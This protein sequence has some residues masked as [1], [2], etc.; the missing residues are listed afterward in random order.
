MKLSIVTTLY[1]SSEYIYEFHRR[2]SIACEAYFND[3]ELIFVNDGSTDDSLK[4]ILTLQATDD[5]IKIIDLSRNY[6]HHK[7]IMTGL[8]YATGDYVFLTDCDLEEPPESF[9]AFWFE[10]N[11]DHGV[12]VIYATQ[13][14]R[15]GSWWE[16]ISG[17][18]VWRI[19]NKFSTIPI[20]LNLITSRLMN[21]KFISALREFK[22]H[23][24]FLASII[25]SA[26]FNQVGISVAKT[27]KASS[28]YNIK[29]KIDLLING[30]TSFSSTPLLIVFY[31]GL[32][33]CSLSTVV[34]ITF[35]IK[36]LIS[37][38]APSGW[39]SLLISIWLLGGIIIFCIG[40]LGIY[41]S[42]IFTE[43]K[44]RPYTL[45]KN[46]YTIENNE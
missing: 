41:L 19:I 40:I 5:R 14:D 46:I 4:K 44:A 29:R 1:Q 2:I 38:S 36:Q 24:V 11:K 32:I 42:R 45:V 22:E 9:A 33:I 28:T 3:I 20:P 13:N 15:K 27:S 30:I 34:A 12:D 26:G 25:A 17:N 18:I 8:N 43:T 21:K 7:A 37:N 39:T 31:L 16:R 10:I 6:G 23:D 35:G